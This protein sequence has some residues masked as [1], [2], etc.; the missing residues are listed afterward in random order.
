MCT[1]SNESPT[2]GTTKNRIDTA[3]KNLTRDSESENQ[4]LRRTIQ[5]NK[6]WSITDTKMKQ[7][8][9]PEGYKD[10][11]PN[12]KGFE[13]IPSQAL[14]E[15]LKDNSKRPSRSQSA[16]RLKSYP[17]PQQT[18]DPELHEGR[19]DAESM[20]SIY[21]KKNQSGMGGSKS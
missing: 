15:V 16:V 3:H 19:S 7:L 14:V 18:D 21:Y 5:L 1:S 17:P 13:S 4:I 6:Q 12:V 10:L 11:T 2:V 8:S 9:Q 20:S